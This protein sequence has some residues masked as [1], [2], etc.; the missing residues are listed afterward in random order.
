VKILV[1]SSNLIG[2][3]VLST[4]VIQNFINKY[5]NSK[6]TIVI[7]PSAAQLYE[8]FPNLDKILIIKKKNFNMHWLE[9]YRKCFFK[10]WDIIIDF[11]SSLISYV[12][13]H[14]GRYIF[15]KNNLSHHLNQLSTYFKFN[16]DNLKVYNS[17]KEIKEANTN[18]D[19]N[20]KYV[21][22]CPG[23][24]WK[25]KI[26]PVQ[27]FNIL[28][29]KIKESYSSTKFI[30]VGS[31][32]ESEQYYSDLIKNLNKDDVIN[33][34]GKSLTLTS[35]YMKRSTLFIGNDSG[36]MHLSVASKLS[37][38]G[39]FG[40]TN[41]KIYSPIGNNCFVIRTKESYDSFSIKNINK[42]LTYMD[43]INSNQI[44]DLIIKEKILDQ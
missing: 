34:M 36:L 3:T 1:I 29:K 28:I 6:L 25:P 43:S 42:E 8:H 32:L 35:A 33:L 16:C 39:L 21:V 30:I 17:D 18:I 7:G 2:D 20:K 15:K 11:R 44:M 40:P 26:W 19:K 38:I 41:D 24:N 27:N 12:L 10:K 4:G 37:T 14:K 9:I 22:I 13:F 23:G 31:K 5:P